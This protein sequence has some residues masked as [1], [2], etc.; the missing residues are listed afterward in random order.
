MNDAPL[1]RGTSSEGK[2]IP[3]STRLVGA[4]AILKTSRRNFRSVPVNS[5]TA[6]H[7][8]VMISGNKNPIALV[9]F[10][11]FFFILYS[12]TAYISLATE[13]RAPKSRAKI[14]IIFK[15]NIYIYINTISSKRK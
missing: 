11:F 10:V 14:N 1:R 12:V 5:I 8:N 13:S 9:K 3:F 15:Y 2:S 4:R 6:N 7:D